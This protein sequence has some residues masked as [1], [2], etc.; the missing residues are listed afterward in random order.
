M[1]L[2]LKIHCSSLCRLSKVYLVVADVKVAI[3]EDILHWKQFLGKRMILF[4]CRIAVCL[5]VNQNW[6]QIL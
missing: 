4:C 6:N 3:N 1:R 5:K 2:D